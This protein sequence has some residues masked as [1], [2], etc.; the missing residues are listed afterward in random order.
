MKPSGPVWTENVTYASAA[1]CPCH[2]T[3]TRNPPKAAW[4]NSASALDSME[5]KSSP[6]TGDDELDLGLMSSVLGRSLED[7]QQ[8]LHLGVNAE[9]HHGR[10]QVQKTPW[11][12]VLGVNREDVHQP[13]IQHSQ[14]QTLRNRVWGENREALH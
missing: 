13:E 7:L 3:G 1:K 10:V 11:D 12:P 4:P 5:P 8:I 9:Q 2:E 14:W 6:E